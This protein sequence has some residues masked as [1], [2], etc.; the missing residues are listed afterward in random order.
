MI[1][2][3]NF[4]H[5]GS[6]FIASFDISF[7]EMDMIMTSNV[8]WEKK[9]RVTERQHMSTGRSESYTHP[10]IHLVD[11]KLKRKEAKI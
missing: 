10:R 2:Q 1:F 11:Q 3:D 5:K 9:I 4:R 7:P 6:N 8:Y